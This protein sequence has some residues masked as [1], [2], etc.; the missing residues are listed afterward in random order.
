MK[1]NLILLLACLVTQLTMAERFL[2]EKNAAENA[3]T[4]K[5]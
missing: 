3:A 2:V 5:E 1:R 4:K